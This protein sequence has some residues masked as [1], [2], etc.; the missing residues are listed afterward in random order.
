MSLE[1]QRPEIFL[2]I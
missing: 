2:S 1:Y